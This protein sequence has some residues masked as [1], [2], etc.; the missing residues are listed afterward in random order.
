MKNFHGTSKE[1]KRKNS[2]RGCKIFFYE[3]IYEAFEWETA[4]CITIE[5]RL[6]RGMPQS[7][8]RTCL[9]RGMSLKRHVRLND[10]KN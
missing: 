7:F 6:L 2:F 4:F 1:K 9:L 3:N 10:W 8:N 5:V